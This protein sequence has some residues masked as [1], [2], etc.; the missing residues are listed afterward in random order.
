M[1]KYLIIIF[2]FCITV[3]AQDYV[4][5]A[6][7]ADTTGDNPIRGWVINSKPIL[8]QKIY[9]TEPYIRPLTQNEALEQDLFTIIL[10]N[11][12]QYAKE[13]YVDSTQHE[14]L[15]PCYSLVYPPCPG[16]P[17]NPP[18]YYY[19]HKETSFE[20]FIAWLRKQLERE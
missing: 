7:T 3:S 18:K 17:Y 15:K 8:D 1:K 9:S 6:I 20:G 5:G 4:T 2:L 12:D 14:E 19:T 10:R 16:H 11:F 13:C